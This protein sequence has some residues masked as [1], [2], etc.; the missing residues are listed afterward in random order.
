MSEK[1][2][3]FLLQIYGI[4]TLVDSDAVATMYRATP[5]FEAV[6]I[7]GYRYFTSVPVF[8]KEYMP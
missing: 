1:L 8:N 3:S 2:I 4:L 7:R 5:T 6:L